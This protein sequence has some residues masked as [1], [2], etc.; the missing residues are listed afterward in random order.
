MALLIA[1]MGIEAIRVYWG[2]DP[3]TASERSDFLRPC[4]ALFGAAFVVTSL[5]CTRET[6]KTNQRSVAINQET[7]RI[8]AQNILR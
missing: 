2:F 3:D 8:N 5:Y 7:V 6:L 1:L 4:A